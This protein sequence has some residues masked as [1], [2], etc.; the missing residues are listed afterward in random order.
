MTLWAE[1]RGVSN[2]EWS[3]VQD[4]FDKHWKELGCPRDMM[5]VCVEGPSGATVRLI[6]G[7]PDGTPLALYEGFVEISAEQLPRAANRQ[8]G[9]QDRFQE[10]F[11]F[12]K[13]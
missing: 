6:A 2:A 1:K 12:P 9:H 8:V 10:Q 7:L 3:H 11:G 13:R 5:L 4:A